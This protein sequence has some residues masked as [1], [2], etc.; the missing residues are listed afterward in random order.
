MATATVAELSRV[1]QWILSTLETD[2]SIFGAVGTRIYADQA[3]QG[4]ASPMIVFS[5]LG[6]ADK[7]I[8][9]SSR[10]T[11]TLYLVRAIAAGLSYDIV[12]DVADRIEA[13]LA[14]PDGGQI[15][16]NVRITSVAREQ[17]FQRKD[18]ENGVPY[19]HMGGFYRIRFQPSS[20]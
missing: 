5:F 18:A 3:P 14:V 8:T 9:G 7:V 11:Q 4:A 15:V 12:D 13:V 17:P 2:Q 16:R 6:G 1:N 19:V 10:L 20:Q